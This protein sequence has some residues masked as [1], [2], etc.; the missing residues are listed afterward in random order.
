MVFGQFQLARR[1][2]HALAFDTPQHAQL[3][4]EG[5]RIIGWRWQLGT[6]QRARHLDAH[7]HVRCAADDA[8]RGTCTD[9]HLAD[10]ELVGIRMSLDCQHL[11]HD[12][13]R[14]GRRHSACGFHLHA[15]HGQQVGQRGG[16]DGRVAELAQ[17]RLGK[18]HLVSLPNELF[19]LRQ[20]AQVAVEEQ[21]QVV[22][23]VAQHRQAIRP[24]P[25]S[26]TDVALRVEPEV[27][28]H[29]RV[30]LA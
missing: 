18:L 27:A 28:H 1:A 25:E 2:Q 11:A 30:H 26:E 13:M 8:E 7:A 4:L 17:P 10:I 22:D 23:A 5:R 24:H 14:E 21:A 20:K 16:V 15:C 29:V 12:D 3:D 19:E 6:H 9:V